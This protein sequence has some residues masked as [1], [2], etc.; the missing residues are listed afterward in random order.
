MI[1]VE[2]FFH[3]RCFERLLALSSPEVLPRVQVETSSNNDFE[4]LLDQGAH[5][6]VTEWISRRN[7]QPQRGESPERQTEKI[8][9]PPQEECRREITPTKTVRALPA[10]TSPAGKGSS[11]TKDSIVLQV[12]ELQWVES[13]KRNAST[14]ENCPTM[15]NSLGRHKKFKMTVLPVGDSND[16]DLEIEES[17]TLSRH[18]AQSKDH[19]NGDSHPGTETP[20]MNSETLSTADDENESLDDS[21]KSWDLLDHLLKTDDPRFNGRHSLSDALQ[22]WQMAQVCTQSS[23]ETADIPSSRC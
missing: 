12:S 9:S 2:D 14:F 23:K 16:G 10:H 20:P 6:L 22:S 17:A 4:Y 7:P 18:A 13:R 8:S 1:S 19:H 15:H 21:G 3:V 5:Q 11:S